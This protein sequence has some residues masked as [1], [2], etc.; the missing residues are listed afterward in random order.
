MD[1]HRAVINMVGKDRII[2]SLYDGNGNI[3]TFSY[4]ISSFS[5]KETE[6]AGF[7]EIA[8]R[9]LNSRY[10]KERGYTGEAVCIKSGVAAINPGEVVVFVGGF[11]AENKGFGSTHLRYPF[12]LN[13]DGYIRNPALAETEFFIIRR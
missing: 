2:V 3:S 7:T 12:I 5:Y 8:A 1:I 13:D 4:N 11:T 6:P 9:A 10:A